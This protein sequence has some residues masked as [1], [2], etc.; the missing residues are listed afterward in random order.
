MIWK[1]SIKFSFKKFTVV[2]PPS[3]GKSDFPCWNRTT[4]DDAWQT[5]L[6]PTNQNIF[7]HIWSWQDPNRY[8]SFLW[9][10]AHD[11]ILTND[12]RYHRGMTKDNLCPICGDYLETVM[13]VVFNRKSLIGNQLLRMVTNLV[14][15]IISSS[16]SNEEAQSH[17]SRHIDVSWKPPPQD[18]YKVNIDESHKKSTR[19]STCGGLIRDSHGKFIC[20]FYNRLVSCYFVWVKLWSLCIGIDMTSQFNIKNIIF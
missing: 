10:I 2:K 7:Q 4:D 19:I 16:N 9:N 15:F 20:G 17:Q 5:S 13:H 18:H 6:L 3:N 11:K 14:N 1:C 8:K 12:A